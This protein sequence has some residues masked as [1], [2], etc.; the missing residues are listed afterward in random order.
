MFNIL[1]HQ[2]NGNQNYTEII[3]RQSQN[4]Y[5]QENKQQMLMRILKWVNPYT[6]GGNIN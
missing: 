4:G 2:R 6:L 5:D 3:P 1:S